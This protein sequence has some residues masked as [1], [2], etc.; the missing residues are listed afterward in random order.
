[1]V[2]QQTDVGRCSDGLPR[3]SLAFKNHSWS[4]ANEGYFY[5]YHPSIHLSLKL[6]TLKIATSL[7]QTEQKTEK[8]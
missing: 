1:M 4:L 5:F 7:L 2:Q 3:R 6:F 8:R